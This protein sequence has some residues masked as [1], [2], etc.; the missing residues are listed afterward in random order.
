M[1]RRSGAR[2]GFIAALAIIALAAVGV[3]AVSASPYNPSEVTT[4]ALDALSHQNDAVSAGT[5]SMTATAAAASNPRF[6]GAAADGMMAMIAQQRANAA[7]GQMYPGS[8]EFSNVR[9][10]GMSG[11]STS[12][13]VDLQAHQKLANMQSGKVVNYSESEMVY[14]LVLDRV[15]GQWVVSQLDWAFAPGYEP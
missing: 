6:R 9:V 3:M 2:A 12:V 1:S 7:A 8:N 10:L 15:G 11:T 4:A 13:R 14:H 5:P